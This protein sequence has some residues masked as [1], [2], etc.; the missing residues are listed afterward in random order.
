MT[1]TLFGASGRSGLPF[2]EQAVNENH[3]IRAAVRNADRWQP[4]LPDVKV[5]PGNVLS[6]E[7][8]K[9]AIAG[10]DA[11]VSVIGQRKD[12]PP[13]LLQRAAEHIVQGMNEHGVR[14]LIVLTGG[15]V[16]V[17]E[18]RPG[19]VDWFFKTAL[20]IVRPGLLEDAIRYIEI[21]RQS[22]LDWT[23]VRVPML[24]NKP[25]S[26]AY[27]VGYAG[28]GTGARTSRSHVARFILDELAS[29]N[30]VGD[31]PMVTD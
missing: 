1:I 29:N 24:H 9:N 23:V 16:E 28:R 11:V 7:E 30:H 10:A 19:L 26:G 31:A 6:P 17:P 20:R 18:D 8:V 14:R 5:V 2:I 25:V 22:G 12:S 15:G 13:D 21:V 27:R 4:P 3:T